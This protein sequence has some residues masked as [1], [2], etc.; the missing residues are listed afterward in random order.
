MD[1]R[2]LSTSEI[3]DTSR[4]YL[5]IPHTVDA[6]SDQKRT[7]P[8]RPT[9]YF[10][11]T[12]PRRYGTVRYGTVLTPRTVS[13]CY[14]QFSVSYMGN[15]SHLVSSFIYHV[16][17]HQIRV[18]NLIQLVADCTI[19]KLLQ[20]TMMLFNGNCFAIVLVTSLMY[21]HQATGRYLL[22]H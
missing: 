2:V 19:L 10:S 12:V 5:L 7:V 4:D 9:Y 1:N 6:I 16:T 20:I 17:S 18:Y 3:N 11:N 13:L 21:I 8:Y 15:I 22:M 14:G